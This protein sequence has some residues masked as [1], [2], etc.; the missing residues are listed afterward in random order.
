MSGNRLCL[1]RKACREARAGVNQGV[2]PRKKEDEKA[3]CAHVAVDMVAYMAGS[4]LSPGAGDHVATMWCT[5]CGALVYKSYAGRQ[6]AARVVH[7]RR[8]RPKGS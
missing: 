1:W 8:T 7:P 6:V 4:V 5:E 2:P 3:P